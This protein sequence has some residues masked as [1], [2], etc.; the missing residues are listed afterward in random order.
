MSHWKRIR[1]MS[2]LKY[3]IFNQTNERLNLRWSKEDESGGRGEKLA[4]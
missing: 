1:V 2:L 3:Q 4:S